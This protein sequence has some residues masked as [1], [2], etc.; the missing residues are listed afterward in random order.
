MNSET[1]KCVPGF[2][3]DCG[4][5][6]PLLEPTGNVTCYTCKKVFGPEGKKFIYIL[7]N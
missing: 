1:F 5:I 3:N 4:S 7:I 2:C 6:L